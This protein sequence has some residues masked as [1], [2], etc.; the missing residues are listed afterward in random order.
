MSDKVGNLKRIDL[1]KTDN[2]YNFIRNEDEKLLR[3]GFFRG[4]EFSIILSSPRSKS[5]DVIMK[6][7]EI[8]T[9]FNESS[10]EIRIYN[11][12]WGNEEES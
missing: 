6:Y 9:G 8:M 7:S 10:C 11:L 5:N 12:R 4:Y 3:R 1:V 2:S